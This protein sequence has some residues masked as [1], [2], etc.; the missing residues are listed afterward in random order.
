M[1]ELGAPGVKI[2]EISSGPRPVSMS[3][4]TETGFVGLVT[5]PETFFLGKLR[6]PS[7]S[8]DGWRPLM[9]LP[10]PSHTDAFGSWQSA[11]AFLPFTRLPEKKGSNT[12]P[13][14]TFRFKGQPMERKDLDQL[15]KEVP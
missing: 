15:L 11:L 5:I 6:T 14:A 13:P 8:L 10:R 7:L 4:T 2:E 12:L 1:P 3:G 9:P